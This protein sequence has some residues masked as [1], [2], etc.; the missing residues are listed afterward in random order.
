MQQEFLT[1]KEVANR[2]RVTTRSVTEWCMTGKVRATR[3]GRRWRIYAADFDQVLKAREE[4]VRSPK[5][6]GLALAY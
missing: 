3:V 4:E 5:A 2:L 6:N 1:V